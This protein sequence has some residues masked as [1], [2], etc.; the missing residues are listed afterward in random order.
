VKDGFK[1]GL[2]Q[3]MSWLHTW[4]GLVLAVLLYFMFVTGSVG[5]FNSEVDRWMRA[6]PKPPAAEVARTLMVERAVARLDQVSTQPAKEWYVNLPQGRRSAHITIDWL[7]LAAADGTEPKFK[8]ETLDPATGLPLAGGLATGGGNALYA[9]HWALHYLPERVALYLVGVATM[10]MFVAIV[11]GIVVHKKIFTDFF[12]FRPAKGQR[13]WLDAH[14]VS[15]VM[16]LPYFLMITY[17][18]L[19]FY[20][21]EYMPSV[22]LALYGS[23]EQAQKVFEREVY[24]EADAAVE[25]SGK[26]APM[27]PIAAMVARAEAQWGAGSVS[28]L[29][30]KHPGDANARVSIHQFD[31]ASGVIRSN[32]TMLFDGASGEA[33]TMSAEPKTATGTFAEVML[34]LHEGHFAGPLLR[35]LYFATGLLGAG[36]IATGMVLWTAKRRQHLKGGE[37]AH[38]G[39]RLVERM[40]VGTIVGLLVAIAAYFWANRLIPLQLPERD[41]WEMHALFIAWA[42]AFTHASLRPVRR[43]WVEQF[44]AAGALYALLPLI[45]LVTTD[46]HLGRTLPAGDW[47]LAGFDLTML[48]L[49]ALFAWAARRTA[50]ATQRDHAA[51][52]PHST[53]PQASPEP[54]M[55]IEPTPSAESPPAWPAKQEP[56]SLPR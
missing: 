24:G 22:K 45:N 31:A 30:V 5:Y 26:T 13:S 54:A 3:S 19:V 18:G 25:P 8:S 20:T 29:S 16:A 53:L 39:L 46:T 17:S 35:W 1:G 52:V 21:Y 33:L 27:A 40:N 36:M 38:A 28:S 6:E 56:S 44:A 34:S 7:P 11:T 2:R 55:R 43:A 48:V 23:G 12:T 15:S 42:L 47:V 14:N 50:R 41:A 9:M 10:F 37:P 49:G 51:A 32:R 4:V